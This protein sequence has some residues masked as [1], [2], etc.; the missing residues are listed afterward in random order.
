MA[1]EPA[2]DADFAAFLIVRKNRDACIHWL[3]TYCQAI[4][5]EWSDAELRRRRL[6]SLRRCLA[7]LAE[8]A[9]AD[10]RELAPL[11]PRM[12]HSTDFDERCAHRPPPSGR[13]ARALPAE[14]C[15]CRQALSQPRAADRA[16]SLAWP[17][18]RRASRRR[19][20]ASAGRRQ[21]R[22]RHMPE[23]FGVSSH[24]R[25]LR[26]HGRR[27]G[28]R[29]PPAATAARR[30]LRPPSLGLLAR[31][32]LEP[33]WDPSWRR[34]ATTSAR[35]S[36]SVKR[37]IAVSA[38]A[39]NSSPWV[40]NLPSTPVKP[41]LSRHASTRRSRKFCVV[42]GSI[43]RTAECLGV[44]RLV[45]CGYTAT[46]NDAQAARTSMGRRVITGDQ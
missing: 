42:P 35:P 27:E 2:A 14:R 6:A 33:S 34:S 24:R 32:F 9:H 21:G 40:E 26:Q 13:A 15:A 41:L 23:T 31:P 3:L 10:C 16:P 36:T 11:A 29:H 7:S 19:F 5:R 44:S 30:R 43:F 25:H 45:L 1:A 8:H 12:L 17:P 18:R 37:P 46:P 39:L 22:A 38:N 28:L 4:E 20:D